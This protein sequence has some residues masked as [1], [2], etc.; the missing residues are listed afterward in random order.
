[1]ASKSKQKD[2]ITS[3]DRESKQQDSI[4]S[5]HRESKQKD[6]ITSGGKLDGD[7]LTPDEINDI[8]DRE[9]KDDDHEEGMNAD[10]F[11]DDD[12]EKV[13]IIIEGRLKSLQRYNLCMWSF[14]KYY[15]VN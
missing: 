2:S 7:K 8:D 12:E 15:T 1:M 13:V 3:G 4:I 9:N 6:S 5:G 10:P 11:N 14:D